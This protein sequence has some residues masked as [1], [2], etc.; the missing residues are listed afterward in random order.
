MTL[1]LSLSY[2]IE[3]IELRSPNQKGMIMSEKRASVDYPIHE[4]LGE[5]WSPYAFQ[6]RPVSEA[7]RRSLFEAA[8]WSSANFVF[9]VLRYSHYLAR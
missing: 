4:F 1:C 2:L 7:D 9:S 8:R 3:M 6:D 5:R